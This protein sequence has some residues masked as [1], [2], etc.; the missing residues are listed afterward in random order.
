MKNRIDISTDGINAYANIEVGAS[1]IGVRMLSILLIVEIILVVGLLSQIK[2]EEAISLIIPMVI[3]LVIFVGL[4]FKYLLWNLY[5]KEEL[6]VNSKSISWAYNYGFFKTNLKTVN[7]DRLGTGYE[8]VRGENEEEV[9]RLVFY[10]YRG[11]DNVPELIHQTTVLLGKDEIEEFDN[12]ISNV[13]ANEF[14]NKN[15]FIPFSTN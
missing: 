12:Q 11:E 4:P 15:G 6:I 8:R 9:G 13:F 10:N 14:L 1:K 5:G 2:S 3:G 7:Y